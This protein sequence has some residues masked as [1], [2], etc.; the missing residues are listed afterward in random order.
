MRASSRLRILSCAGTAHPPTEAVV[1]VTVHAGDK[2]AEMYVISATAAEEFGKLL[3][4]AA[5]RARK[6][7][8]MNYREWIRDK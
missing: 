7:Q 4:G 6:L 2:K 3:L 5:K 1:H 8:R